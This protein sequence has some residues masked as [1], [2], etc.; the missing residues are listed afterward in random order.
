[1]LSK[2][3]LGITLLNLIF[4]NLVNAENPPESSSRDLYEDDPV[5]FLSVVI[6]GFAFNFL[7]LA[8]IFFVFNRIY[9]RWTH[10]H[11][12]LSMALRVP[13]YLGVLDLVFVIFM[14]VSIVHL[15]I[16][17][18]PLS[19]K[20]CKSNAAITVAFTIFHR[21]VI[22]GIS[23]IT[24]LRVCRQKVCNTGRYDWKLFLPI[25][26]ISTTLSLLSL[27]TYGTNVYWCGAKPDTATVPIFSIFM[28][29]FVL[30][31]CLFCYIQTIRVIR[32][33][34]N[35]QLLIEN[36]CVVARTSTLKLPIDEVEI[37]VT[38]KVLGYILVYMIQWLPDIPYDI[39]SLVG[40]A[41]PWAYCLVIVAV[42]M[43]SIGNAIFYVINEGMSRHGSSNSSSSYEQVTLKDT[44]N[45]KNDAKISTAV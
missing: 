15:A 40:H 9:Y 14:T 21:L 29:L 28:T 22:A 11:K 26:I 23:V 36:R 4:E 18:T 43:G 8:G 34:K 42:H 25:A 33:I 32:A 17:H 19:A 16:Y 2:Y 31:I 24:Y 12:S 45:S 38:T 6:F 13:F 20:V 37:K 5:G 41:E 27:P 35:N 44:S 10:K 39:Y 30:F 3:L 1:M 7:A